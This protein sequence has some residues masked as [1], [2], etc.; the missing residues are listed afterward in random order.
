LNDTLQ[1]L[2]RR[3]GH[4]FR[5]PAILTLALTHRSKSGINNERLEFLGDS[6]LSFIIADALYE[7]FPQL[8]EGDLTRV[9]ATLVRQE[10]LSRLARELDIGNCLQL[11]GGELKSGGFD[12]DS[13]LAD[14]FEAILG[15]VYRDGGMPAVRDVVLQ[16]YQPIFQQ[17]DPRNILKDPKT[18]LQ[19]YLQK[20][21][22]APPVY[23]VL[24]ISGEAHQQHFVV[25]CRVVGLDS[26]VRGE[27]SSR[28]H[29]EQAAAA[30]SCQQLGCTADD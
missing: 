15:A 8:S 2:S 5:D 13:I 22:F 14:A 10:T 1:N 9:R 6:V 27:G 11:G 20:R 28:R 25:Q 3:L 18:R 29:A 4:T 23:E 7:R 12:R 21:G 24:D 19:E 26:P 30:L 17:I 16:L